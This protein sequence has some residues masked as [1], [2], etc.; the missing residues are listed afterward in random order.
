MFSDDFVIIWIVLRPI[1]MQ[2]VQVA[3]AVDVVVTQMI[4]QVMG[5]LVTEM[6]IRVTKEV[7][8]IVVEH[9]GI[10]KVVMFKLTR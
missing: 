3:M 1:I 9:A 8:V 7:F 6:E 2:V 5:F 10:V 4:V